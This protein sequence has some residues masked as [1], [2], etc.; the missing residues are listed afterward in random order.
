MEP[1]PEIIEQICQIVRMGLDFRTACLTHSVDSETIS[2]W[3]ENIRTEK[4]EPWKTFRQNLEFAEAQCRTILIQ[5]I[6]AE[7]GGNGAKFILQNIVGKS[8][9]EISD[10][11]KH[12]PYAFLKGKK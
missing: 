7:G 8:E 6:L 10:V 1:T 4:G 5:R 11:V 9:T 2:E 3:Q 12:D